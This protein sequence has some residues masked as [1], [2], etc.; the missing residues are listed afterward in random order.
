MT[1]ISEHN[2]EQLLAKLQAGEEPAFEAIYR[3]YHLRILFFA[4]RFVSEADAKDVVSESFIR[5]WE[6]R[7]DFSTMGAVAQ[8]LFVTSRNRCLNLVRHRVLQ[9]HKQNEILRLLET[10]EEADLFAEAVTTEVLRLLH[11]EIQ[12]LPTRMQEIFIL[13]FQEGLKPRQIAERLGLSVQTVSNQKVSAIR[14]LREALGQR[15]ALLSL[16][17]L[18]AEA[19]ELLIA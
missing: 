2:D 6:K 4:Q 10:S 12:R 15:G 14:L 8:F 9:Q 1:E 11:E 3:R 5:L 16:L 13:S 18:L 19:E 7:M 17:L